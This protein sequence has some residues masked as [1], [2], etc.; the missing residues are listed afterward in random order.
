MLKILRWW[1]IQGWPHVR[2]LLYGSPWVV[3]MNAPLLV[4]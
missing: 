3:V 2:P 1:D 4:G